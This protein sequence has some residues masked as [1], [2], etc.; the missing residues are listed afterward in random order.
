MRELRGDKSQASVAAV[1]NIAQ[2]TYAGWEKDQRKPD[3]TEL[4]GICKH[5]GVSSDWLLG[6]NHG[7]KMPE[8][9]ANLV[10]AETHER[11]M[12]DDCEGCREKDKIIADQADRIARQ[13]RVIDKLIK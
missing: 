7:H 10:A 1:F 2:Q 6:L 12:Q 3:L 8:E 4:C 11:Y 13:N 9:K 5:Y